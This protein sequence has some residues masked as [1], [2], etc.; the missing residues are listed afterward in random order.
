MA[1]SSR[2][3]SLGMLVTM[4]RREISAPAMPNPEEVMLLVTEWTTISAPCCSG[5]IRAGVA[6]VA[7]T[8]SGMPWLCASAATA[9]TS[10][11]AMLGFDGSSP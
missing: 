5:R 7:S 2:S 1:K 3:A 9:A 10:K 11:K 4:P 6:T 8:I